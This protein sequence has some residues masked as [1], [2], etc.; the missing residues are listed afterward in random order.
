MSLGLIY[1]FYPKEWG[2]PG[3]LVYAIPGLWT[4]VNMKELLVSLHNKGPGRDGENC[5]AAPSKGGICEREKYMSGSE[6]VFLLG[7]RKSFYCLFRR[8][9]FCCCCCCHRFF[10]FSFF[11]YYSYVHT[12]IGSFLPTAPT[13]FVLFFSRRINQVFGGF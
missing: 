11:F 7:Y 8:F 9:F 5:Q 2:I 4:G 6:C 12:R 3:A 13:P 10:F 1:L